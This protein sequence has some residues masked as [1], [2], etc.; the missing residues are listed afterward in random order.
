MLCYFLANQTRG[1]KRHFK[2][3]SIRNFI[4]NIPFK[5]MFLEDGSQ[6]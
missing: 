1:G 6:Q 5:K 3:L 4:S 2:Y